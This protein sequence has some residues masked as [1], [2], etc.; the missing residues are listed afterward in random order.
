MFAIN[1]RFVLKL[2]SCLL[3][4]LVISNTTHRAKSAREKRVEFSDTIKILSQKTFLFS[5]SIDLINSLSI[6]VA[7]KRERESASL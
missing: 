4:L 7:T 6:A 2:I 5:L 1:S 3:N